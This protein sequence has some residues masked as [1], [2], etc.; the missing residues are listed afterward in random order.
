MNERYNELVELGEVSTE[1][2]GEEGDGNDA[3]LPPDKFEG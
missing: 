2:M 1:T 3:A